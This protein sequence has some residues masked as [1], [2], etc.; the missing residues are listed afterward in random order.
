MNWISL[1]A[2]KGTDETVRVSNNYRQK[3]LAKL[4]MAYN[5]GMVSFL[6]GTLD[7]EQWVHQQSIT[8]YVNRGIKWW[9]I[10]C[11]PEK[12]TSKKHIWVGPILFTLA[13]YSYVWI[14][15]LVLV[16]PLCIALPLYFPFR[17][18]DRLDDQSVLLSPPFLPVCTKSD[19]LHTKFP[20]PHFI[21]CL[22]QVQD[23]TPWS[24]F[25]SNNRRK[26]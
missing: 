5:S 17:P 2:Q 16:I 14:A 20:H 21:Y 4:V 1:F 7:K 23:S 13:T 11:C 24:S 10:V 6:T 8:M 26:K 19:V 25:T 18:R 12:Q 15:N 9:F 22:N 3:H